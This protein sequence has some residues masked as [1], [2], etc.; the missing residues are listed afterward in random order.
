MMKH[1]NNT[2][3][4]I[5]FHHN[6]SKIKMDL[7]QKEYELH[8]LPFKTLVHECIA[9]ILGIHIKKKTATKLLDYFSN[10][11][12]CTKKSPAYLFNNDIYK[13]EQY[14][15]YYEINNKKRMKVYP[16]LPHPNLYGV[17]SNVSYPAIQNNIDDSI[18]SLFVGNTIKGVE[19]VIFKNPS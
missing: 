12:D 5:T 11:Q 6:K 1:I 16:K 4:S 10:V 3:K 7:I 14:M 8:A 13:F 18:I 15:V 17:R 2:L 9:K 19:H